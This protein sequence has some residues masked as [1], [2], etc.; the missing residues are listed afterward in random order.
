MPSSSSNADPPRPPAPP[1]FRRHLPPDPDKLLADI[2][3]VLGELEAALGRNDRRAALDSAGFLVGALTSAGREGEAH[4]LGCSYLADARAHAHWLESGWLLHTTATAAQYLDRRA[5]ANELFGE[6]LE[7]C[8]EHGWRSLEHFVLH[9]WGRSLVE[10]GELDRAAD[11]FRQALAIRRQT[12][13][14]LADSTVSALAELESR[15]TSAA[16]SGCA[17]PR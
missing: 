16:D 4:A 9:H 11:A 3:R 8:R 1:H 15:R 13:H 12:G 14:P 10:E 7:A 17:G 2:A 5:E 6:A